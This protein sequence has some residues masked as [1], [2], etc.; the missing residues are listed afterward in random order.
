MAEEAGL[1]KR[2]RQK[3]RRDAKLV[4][5]R[6]EAA[7]ARRRRLLTFAVVGLVL[8]GLV[9]LAVANQVRQRAEVTRVQQEAAAKLDELGC[10][11]DAAMDDLG[12]GHLGSNQEL[13]ANPPETLY[14]DRP[15]SSGQHVGSV[16]Q[17]GVYDAQIDERLLVHDLEH[18]YILGYYSPD[19]PPEQIEQL[20]QWGSEAIDGD[21]AK[22]IV[23][24]Y[25]AGLPDGANFAYVAWGFRQVCDTFDPDVA[26]AFATAHHGG[27]GIAPETTVPA[28]IGAGQGQLAPE[29]GEPLL[30]PPLAG[31]GEGAAPSEGGT[32]GGQPASEAATEG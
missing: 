8:V 23:A 16:A 14:P 24:P 1:S 28:H 3:A 26:Q 29:G 30:L 22:T 7:T 31:G 32:E 6:R 4:E 25:P 18:G 20:K 17:T 27:A 19:A 12:G 15:A 9:G 10:T 13:I 2:E 5:Q 21:F 11:E